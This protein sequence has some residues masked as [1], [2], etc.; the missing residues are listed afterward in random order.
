VWEV[1]VWVRKR[2]VGGEAGK[3]GGE[4]DGGEGLMDRELR[5]L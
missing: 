1:E 4:G 2:K 3:S 5:D